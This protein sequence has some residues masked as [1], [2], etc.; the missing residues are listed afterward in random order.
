MVFMYFTPAIHVGFDGYS[1]SVLYIYQ[2]MHKTVCS[3]EAQFT[4][5]VY[6]HPYAFP[7][8]PVNLAFSDSRFWGWDRSVQL[9]EMWSHLNL[10]LQLL[11]LY[12]NNEKSKNSDFAA[13]LEN[14]DTVVQIPRSISQSAITAPLVFLE[15]YLNI[16]LT[17]TINPFSLLPL[18][19]KEQN[20]SS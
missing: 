19:C 17:I 15:I 7:K 16:I 12:L 14:L 2:F 1:G 3:L 4:I 10:S 20:G 11:C 5:S 9:S 13:C 8:S 18:G 6:P